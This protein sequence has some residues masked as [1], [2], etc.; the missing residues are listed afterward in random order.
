[1]NSFINNIYSDYMSKNSPLNNTDY[2]S[3]QP[4]K[5]VVN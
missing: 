2:L 5:D 4:S 1:M 3:N